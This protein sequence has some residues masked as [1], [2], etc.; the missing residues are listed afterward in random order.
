MRGYPMESGE[1]LDWA[2]YKFISLYAE[3]EVSAFIDIDNEH[4]NFL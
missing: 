3:A 2:G 1:L 4:T